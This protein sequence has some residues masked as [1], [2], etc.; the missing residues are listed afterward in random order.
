MENINDIT[1]VLVPSECELITNCLYHYFQYCLKRRKPPLNTMTKD[2]IATASIEI[3]NDF[4]SLLLSEMALSNRVSLI[5]DELNNPKGI[6]QFEFVSRLIDY[7][8]INKLNVRLYTQ[9]T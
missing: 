3:L 8:F 4:N 1:T 2:N 6:M 7:K 5:E 9:S